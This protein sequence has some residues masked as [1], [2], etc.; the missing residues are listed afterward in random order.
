MDDKTYEISEIARIAQEI[1]EALQP[2]AEAV[3]TAIQEFIERVREMF[4]RIAEIARLHLAYMKKRL[5]IS[6]T[7]NR[8]RFLHIP[9]TLAVIIAYLWVVK[10][11]PPHTVLTG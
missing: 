7:Y 9:H 5:R 4:V 10:R 8:L 11:W 2:I 1:S 3:C 6:Q